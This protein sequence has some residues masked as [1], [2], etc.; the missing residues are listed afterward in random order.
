MLDGLGLV[1]DV[2]PTRSPA[3]W[4]DTG[5][6]TRPLTGGAAS[7]GA[8]KE[9]YNRG[10]TIGTTVARG[11]GYAEDPLVIGALALAKS[12]TRSST[13]PCVLQWVIMPPVTL[14]A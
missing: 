7:G 10:R 8:S 2:N 6:R 12:L 3:H 11:P 1:H 13:V 5:R 9:H 4:N 14:M